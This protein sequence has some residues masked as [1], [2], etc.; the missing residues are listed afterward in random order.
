MRNAVISGLSACV[1]VAEGRQGSGT[2]I[3]AEVAARQGRPLL[4]S[5]HLRGESWVA[6]LQRKHWV[7]EVADSVDATDAI[8]AVLGQK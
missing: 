4:V 1:V 7:I 3:A 6:E 5:E 8:A 2:Q